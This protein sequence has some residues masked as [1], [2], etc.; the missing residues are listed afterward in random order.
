MAGVGLADSTRRLGKPATWGSGGARSFCAGEHPLHSELHVTHIHGCFWV[1]RSPV[2]GPNG[3]S[4]A[5]YS[6]WNGTTGSPIHAH[7]A[8]P[9]SGSSYSFSGRFSE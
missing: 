8:P 9:Y 1:R 3:G 6:P 5:S 2:M 4:G 7:L